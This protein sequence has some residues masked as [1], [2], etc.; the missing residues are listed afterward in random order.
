MHKLIQNSGK[1]NFQ[2]CR[3]RVN[4][5]INV[6]FMRK[7]LVNYK[8]LLVCDLLEFGFPISFEGSTEKLHT[9]NQFWKYK[10]H[11]GAR[12]FPEAINAYIEKEIKYKAI[13]GPFKNNPFQEKIIIS[14]EFCSKER[15]IRKKNH[16]GS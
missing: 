16:Y 1:Y 9:K 12:E 14:P 10:N 7:M 8:D 6:E 15:L 11:T 3:I 13:W 4:F 5:K 2:Q